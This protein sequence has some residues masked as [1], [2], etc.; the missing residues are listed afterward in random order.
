MRVTIEWNWAAFVLFSL[1]SR[2]TS[3]H[4]S[5][6]TVNGVILS[7]GVEERAA[8]FNLTK[9]ANSFQTGR[10]GIHRSSKQVNMCAFASTTPMNMETYLD[11]IETERISTARMGVGRALLCQVLVREQWTHRVHIDTVNM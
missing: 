4:Q 9:I 8:K 10:D 11:P 7:G 1:R 3:A 5:Y 2:T 6:V